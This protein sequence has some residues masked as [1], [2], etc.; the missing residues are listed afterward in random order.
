MQFGNSLLP[1]QNIHPTPKE[2]ISRHMRRRQHQTIHIGIGRMHPQPIRSERKQ[3]R[4]RRLVRFRIIA[5]V[6]SNV[7]RVGW[8]PGQQRFR[9]REQH[10]IQIVHHTTSFGNSRRGF[11]QLSMDAYL[12]EGGGEAFV[13]FGVGSVWLRFGLGN[14]SIGIGMGI[15]VVIG[16]LLS[17]MRTTLLLAVS[18][19]IVDVVIGLHGGSLVS[20]SFWLA[21]CEI[22]AFL[23]PTT[24]RP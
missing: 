4:C 22:V 21:R 11:D 5:S 1:L 17:P 24:P 19:S 14:S 18:A 12:A 9:P 7:I 13:A 20:G 23:Q 8:R 3:A 15:V 6:V 16:P 2:I 10:G